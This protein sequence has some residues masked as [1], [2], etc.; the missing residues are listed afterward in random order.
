MVPWIQDFSIG[1]HY[2]PQ[3]VRDQ[4][5]AAAELGVPNFLLWNA[6]V[7]YTDEALDPSLVTTRAVSSGSV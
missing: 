5:R 1:Y 7:N 3:Q 6:T 4:I 2:G